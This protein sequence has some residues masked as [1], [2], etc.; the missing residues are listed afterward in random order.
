MPSTSAR[1]AGRA[2]AAWAILFALLSLYWALGGTAGGGTLGVELERLAVER[3]PAVVLAL[4][5]SVLFKLAGAGIVLAL[6][7]S[8]GPRRPLLALV[9][10]AGAAM[11]L[12]GLANLVQH[13][14]MA[15]G[16]IA[17][18]AGLGTAAVPWHLALWDPIWIAGGVL[19]LA[20]AWLVGRAP[21]G[22]QAAST[23]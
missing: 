12:Y 1:R 18:P 7:E 17:T 13:A 8:R 15:T 21:Q 16:A 11:T 19:F 6:V 9:W 23:M 10:L 22:S 4:W 3:D 2:A 20:T 5:A 14:L